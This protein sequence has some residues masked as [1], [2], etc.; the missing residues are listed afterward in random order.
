MCEKKDPLDPNSPRLPNLLATGIL[1]FADAGSSAIIFGFS[2]DSFLTFN[3]LEK[4]TYFIEVTAFGLDGVP[5][6]AD[7]ELHA[8]IE[9]HAVNTFLFAPQPLAEQEGTN[10]LFPHGQDLDGP[11]DGSDTRS[12][13]HTSE[14]QSPCK[15]VCRLLL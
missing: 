10:N 3:V 15:L 8:S 2:Y 5:Q 6:G 7:Y 12:E 4:G 1:R 14:L 9:Q 11:V 13:E